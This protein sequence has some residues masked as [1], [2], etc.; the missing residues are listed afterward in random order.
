MLNKISKVIFY[1]FTFIV[2]WG[3]GS[4]IMDS[5]IEYGVIPTVLSFLIGIPVFIGA[6]ALNKIVDKKLK[7]K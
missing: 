3:A 1:M 7:L 5:F 2:V 4:S 6:I